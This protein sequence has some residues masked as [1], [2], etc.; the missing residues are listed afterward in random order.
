MYGE[1]FDIP[2]PD[3]SIFISWF[4]SGEVFRSQYVWRR[5]HGHLL[6][7]PGHE[8]Y[9]IYYNQRSASITKRRALLQSR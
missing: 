3:E 8:T 5:G 2:E 1:R 7:P 9:P 4:G 6:L